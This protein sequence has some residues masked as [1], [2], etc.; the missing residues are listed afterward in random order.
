MT[1]D[2]GFNTDEI[3]IQGKGL[4]AGFH[5]IMA[6]KEE[7]RTNEN[8]PEN[9]NALVVTWEVC[10]GEYKGKQGD[11]W[12]NINHTTQTTAVIAKETIKRIAIAT[13]STINAQNPIKGRVCVA[14]IA[15]QKANP[16]YT[17]IKGYY[18]EDYAIPSTDDDMPF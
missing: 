12:Y 6:V 13:G 15:T 11:V 5:K 14:K 1:M 4:P 8:K 2:Y 7:F 3:E 9:P 16:Q 10:E 17:E 18:P